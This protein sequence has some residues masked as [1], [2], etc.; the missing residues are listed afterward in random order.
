MRALV[1]VAHPNPTSFTHALAHAAETS[2]RAHGWSIDWHDLYTEQFDPV[3]TQADMAALRAGTPPPD[4]AEHMEHLRGADFVLL[5]FPLW[6]TQ[7]PAIL[8]GYVDRIF[9][10]GVAYQDQP[11]GSLPLLTGKAGGLLITLGAS[12][13]DYAQNGRLDAL[14]RTLDEGVLEYCGISVQLRMLFDR[15]HRTSPEERE[16]MIQEVQ[17]RVAHFAQEWGQ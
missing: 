17:T 6:W 4:M 15:M 16:A 14:Q 7:M 11:A 12:R 9:A 5:A 8:K 1:V 13:E 10:H 3:L 2:L